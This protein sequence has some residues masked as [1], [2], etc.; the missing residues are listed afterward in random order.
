MALEVQGGK[1]E[2]KT[3]ETMKQNKLGERR[4]SLTWQAAGTEGSDLSQTATPGYI[5]VN[6]LSE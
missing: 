6:K 4:D 1:E 2:R 3:Q 5:R